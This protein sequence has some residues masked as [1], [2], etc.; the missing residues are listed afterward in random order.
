MHLVGEASDVK[1]PQSAFAAC[2]LLPL[3]VVVWLVTIATM[4]STT[5]F[6][7]SVSYL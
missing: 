1:C 7:A 6:W 5:W 4:F 2:S 3:F